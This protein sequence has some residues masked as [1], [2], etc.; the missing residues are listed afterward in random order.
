M[1][2]ARAPCLGSPTF[3]VVVR[4]VV[5]QV[6]A[7]TYGAREVEDAQRC[8]TLLEA[9]TISPHVE[10]QQAADQQSVGPLV[11]YQHDRSLPMPL[12]DRA[13][14]GQCA[15]EYI[16]TGFST[17]RSDGERIFLPEGILGLKQ[18]FDLRPTQSSQW[19]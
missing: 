8:R 9:V 14:C 10:A 11:G 12:D 13:Q 2:A 6:Q 15:V 1:S 4:N 7:G 16:D 17:Q 18:A 5:E 3:L 19:P